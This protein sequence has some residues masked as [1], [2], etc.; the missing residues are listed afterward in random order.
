MYCRTGINS[1]VFKVNDLKRLTEIRLLVK[2]GPRPRAWRSMCYRSTSS[3]LDAKS[4]VLG[5]V[6][7]QRDCYIFPFSFQEK[8]CSTA[9]LI[10]LAEYRLVTI[11]RGGRMAGGSLFCSSHFYRK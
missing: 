1:I 9:R 6:T 3:A 11:V 8:E 7:A 10:I 5:F 2:A 4:K